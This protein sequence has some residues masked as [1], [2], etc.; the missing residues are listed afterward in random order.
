MRVD[1]YNEQS[2][3]SCKDGPALPCFGSLLPFEAEFEKPLIVKL[4]FETRFKLSES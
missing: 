3:S 1:G 4:D 2:Q